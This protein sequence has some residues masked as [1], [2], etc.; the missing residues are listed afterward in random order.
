MVSDEDEFVKAEAGMDE[1]NAS[2]KVNPKSELEN[3][4]KQDEDLGKAVE[5]IFDETTE[6]VPKC[7]TEIAVK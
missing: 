6:V 3:L 5:K 4:F 7:W 1:V 2:A